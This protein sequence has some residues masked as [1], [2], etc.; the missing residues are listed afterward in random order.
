MAYCVPLG[1]PHSKFLSWSP[2]D[3]DKALAYQR[4]KLEICNECGT[5]EKEWEEDRDAYVADTRR[6]P[7]C[8]RLETERDYVRQVAEEGG[9]DRGI[10]IFLV[11]RKA[12][13]AQQLEL[14]FGEE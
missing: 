10:K 3:Q 8:E 7:G 11:G 12:Y 1:I 5:R 13:E 2:D 9:S 4:A 6:C 14:E